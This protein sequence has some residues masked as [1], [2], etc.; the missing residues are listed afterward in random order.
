MEKGQFFLWNWNYKGNCL[1]K[2]IKGTVVQIEE[3]LV[4]DC[5]RV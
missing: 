2:D 3:A 5:L 4:N 1:N